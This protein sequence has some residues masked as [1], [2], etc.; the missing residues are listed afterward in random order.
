M[1]SPV[2]KREQLNFSRASCACEADESTI[3][4]LYMHS[5]C[6][7]MMP[8]GILAGSMR[9]GRGLGL[10]RQNVS[11]SIGKPAQVRLVGGKNYCELEPG[12]FNK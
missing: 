10:F 9:S 4:A 11:H 12:A 8:A 5:P 7:A 3:R 2:G 6:L 1:I